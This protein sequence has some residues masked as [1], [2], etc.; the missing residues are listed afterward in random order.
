MNDDSQ[1]TRDFAIDEDDR[2]KTDGRQERTGGAG[3]GGQAVA[4]GRSKRPFIILAIILIILVLIG[5]GYWFYMSRFVTTTDA[6]IDGAIH[7]IAPRISGQVEAVLVHDNQHVTKGQVLV[8]LDSG[9]E[10]V[11]L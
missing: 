9:T 4:R 1:Q 8:Q 10:T 5:T 6:E 2:R 3:A 11:A 7:R